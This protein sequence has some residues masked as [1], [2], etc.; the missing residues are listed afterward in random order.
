MPRRYRKTSTAAP[1]GYFAWEAAGLRWL[2]AAG[3]A[4]VAEVLD[5]GPHHL[6]LPL[7]DAAPPTPRAAED[8]GRGL[9]T[10]HAVGAGGWGAGPDGWDGD[11][12][13]GPLSEPLPLR[14]GRW[15]TWGAFYGQARVL[16]LARLGRERGT[17]DDADVA[18][19]ERL[20]ERVGSGAFDTPDA[21]ARLH[22]DLWSGNVVWTREGAVLID[23]AAHGGH[24]EGDLALL[25]LFGAPGL[26]RLLAAYDEAAPLADGWRSRVQLHQVHPLL[27]HA[28]LFGGG[29]VR[30][31]LD[32]A[33]RYL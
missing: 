4:A 2:G 26:E 32:A 31:A 22:G 3:G 9:A 5:A 15:G 20:A 27:L 18:V 30:Q 8:L 13:L 28:V 7:L 23:P 10:L 6:E 29:Y 1:A 14:L 19:L 33:R 24:R 21:P 16:P 11:G 17:F 25:A 12:W